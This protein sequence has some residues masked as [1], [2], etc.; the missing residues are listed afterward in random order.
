MSDTYPQDTDA[1]RFR[2]YPPPVDVPTVLPGDETLADLARLV[3]AWSREGG[4]PPPE[5]SLLRL[6]DGYLTA[7]ARAEQAEQE[8][9]EW[10]DR[11]MGAE[12]NEGMV[13]SDWKASED[14]LHAAEARV[15]ALETAGDALASCGTMRTIGPNGWLNYCKCCKAVPWC[16]HEPEN[17]DDECPVAE[18]RALRGQAT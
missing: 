4:S 9:D 7:E 2:N 16:D 5:G 17:H 13:V 1:E 11:A 10:K 12:H 6:A 15:A 18:W 3:Q 8:R 14:C